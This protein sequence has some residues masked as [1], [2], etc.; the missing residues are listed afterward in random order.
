MSVLSD[1][2]TP[3]VV[4][5]SDALEL[6]V[7]ELRSL[8]SLCVPESLKVRGAMN[9][10]LFML[11][12]QNGAIKRPPVALHGTRHFPFA[13]SPVHCSTSSIL[14]PKLGETGRHCQATRLSRP[15]VSA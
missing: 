4:D 11:G 10:P 7:Y 13:K 3:I 14:L 12:P 15:A 8:D 1:A 2:Q 5:A 9:A 6:L